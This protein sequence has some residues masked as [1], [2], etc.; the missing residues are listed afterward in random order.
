M[1]LLW[2]GML[3]GCTSEAL[4][5]SGTFEVF[6]VVDVGG[7]D[8]EEPPQVDAV[9]EIDRDDGVLSIGEGAWDLNSTPRGGWV[10]GCPT[11]YTSVSL[12]VLTIE[13]PMDVDGVVLD[14]PMVVA[15]CGGESAVLMEGI[16]ASA[17]G[18]GPC[19]Y[20]RGLCLE[21]RPTSE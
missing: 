2:V 4:V 3:F 5:P 7:G 1:F 6:N 18:G 15:D 16:N 11:N 8:G 20:A 9:V 12:E 21:L 19:S 13:G 17:G 14:A 10:S